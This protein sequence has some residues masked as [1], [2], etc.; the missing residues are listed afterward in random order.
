[1][2]MPTTPMAVATQR[3]QCMGSCKNMAAPI[4]MK[5]GPVKPM[6]VMSASA[7]LGSAMNH[8]IRP[9]VCTAPRKNC[10]LTCLG[11]KGRQPWRQ[12]SGSITM[13]PNR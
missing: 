1:M 3:S 12:T 7:I 2:T 4:M 8:N 10:P 6:A 5:I 13:K 11:T 9:T